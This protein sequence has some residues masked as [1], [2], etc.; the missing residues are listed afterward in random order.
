MVSAV[1]SSA[2][3][4][5]VAPAS[6]GTTVVAHFWASWAP[7]CTQTAQLTEKLAQDCKNLVFVSVEAEQAEDLSEK[8]SVESVPAF[9]FI[10]AGEKVGGVVGANVPEITSQVQ[11]LNASSTQPAAPAGAPTVPGAS[12]V[13]PL[14]AA[15]LDDRLASLVKKAPVMLFMKGSPGAERCG[16]SRKIVEMLKGENIEFGTFDILEDEE[17]RQ[18]LKKFSNWPTYPQLYAKGSLIG[19]LDIVKELQEAGELKDEL[20]I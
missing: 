9:V 8:F 11:A 4:E 15:S 2:E 3:L 1:A 10:R 13:A 19:G 5:K 18:G 7:M 20:G 16:F 6:S 17:V 12:P 14:P